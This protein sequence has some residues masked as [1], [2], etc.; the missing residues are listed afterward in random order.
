MIGI[1]GGSFDPIHIGHLR[2]AEDIREEFSLERVIFVPA[3]HSPL[4]PECKASSEDRLEMIKLSISEN[5]YFDVDDVELRRRG[6]SYTVDTLEYFKGTYNS[7]P[8]FIVGTDAFLTFDRWK[9]PEKILSLTNIIVIGRGNTNKNEVENFLKLKFNKN[10]S[11]ISNLNDNEP[12][13]YF[14]DSRRLDISSTEIRN[15]VSTNK[16]IKYLV[17]PEVENYIFKKRLYR[18]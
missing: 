9:D 12:K 14:F 10:L 18:G 2:I 4:K 13:I 6:K 15:R 17:L 5:K 8:Y 11:E 16:S 3:Y 1:Y 7:F